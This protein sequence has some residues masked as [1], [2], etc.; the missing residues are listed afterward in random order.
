MISLLI[1]DQFQYIEQIPYFIEKNQRFFT[2]LKINTSKYNPLI[3]KLMKKLL[4]HLLIKTCLDSYLEDDF[5]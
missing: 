1:T 2:D 3:F 5:S 4:T